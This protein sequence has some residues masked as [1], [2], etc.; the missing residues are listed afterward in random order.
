MNQKAYS[1]LFCAL[2]AS[3]FVHELRAKGV[4]PVSSRLE[5]FERSA[6]KEICELKCSF[7]ETVTISSGLTIVV[8]EE[9]LV[10]AN[11]S[12]SVAL[13]IDVSAQIVV[14]LD[15]T[16]GAGIAIDLTTQ[17]GV[18]IE[19]GLWVKSKVTIDV[20]IKSLKGGLSAI[21]KITGAIKF[22]LKSA[23]AKILKLVNQIIVKLIADIDA[24]L[25][26]DASFGLKLI[27]AISS[28]LIGL[29]KGSLKGLLKVIGSVAIK[30]TNDLA[31]L[32]NA[33]DGL[34]SIVVKVAGNLTALLEAGVVL[35]LSLILSASTGL[36]VLI[37]ILLQI[38]AVINIG[39]KLGAIL[40][41]P[42]SLF[43]LLAQLGGNTAIGISGALLVVADIIALINGHQ[44]IE[45]VI[46]II[47]QFISVSVHKTTQDLGIVLK[48]TLEGLLEVLS[49]LKATAGLK[50]L[51]TT[52]QALIDGTLVI[53]GVNISTILAKLLAPL[54]TSSSSPL[55]VVI[56]I[57]LQLKGIVQISLLIPYI[58]L[59]LIVK[60]NSALGLQQ[61]IALGIKI[62]ADISSAAGGILKS[63]LKNVLSII[64]GLLT[65]RFYDVLIKLPG[66]G[67]IIKALD[68]ALSAATKGEFSLKALLNGSTSVKDLIKG[69]LQVVT[70]IHLGCSSAILAQ[71]KAI[72]EVTGSA[73]ACVHV[74]V[75]TSI[76]VGG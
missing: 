32:L 50:A 28:Q 41:D 13:L 62:N 30:L 25:V 68:A 36:E 21:L 45:Q 61:L 48:A 6:P 49:H 19:S 7:N 20:F 63:L 2:L 35:N 9:V 75:T 71:I 56:W 52:I 54:H 27:I 11:L 17:T 44:T 70:G 15:G 18:H 40:N 37:N 46:S 4:A 65:G 43:K 26:Q 12:S 1:V 39:E 31:G 10:I 34:A 22:S 60:L 58:L 76:T 8:V 3:T 74:N 51:I 59:V 55:E 33:L 73:S 24:Q 64:T 5:A 72:L 14:L 23:S 66:I 16:T 69:L 53:G 67:T 47:I 57:V 38:G 29:L 42:E